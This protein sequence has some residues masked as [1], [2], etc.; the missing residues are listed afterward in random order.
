[1]HDLMCSLISYYRIVNISK[2]IQC[3]YM[4]L[5]IY[6][7]AKIRGAFSHWA[8][9]TCVRFRE[10]PTNQHVSTNHILITRQ[11]GCVCIQAGFMLQPL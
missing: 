10:V 5:A 9:N 1:M 2:Y 6:Q 3:L 4:L 11:N 7:M 8:E